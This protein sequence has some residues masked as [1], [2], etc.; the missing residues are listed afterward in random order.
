VTVLAQGQLFRNR[1]IGNDDHAGLLLALTRLD[2]HINAVRFVRAGS[3][4][5]T[6]MLREHAWRAVLGLAVL[7]VVWLWRCLPR[8]GPVCALPTRGQR[9]FAAHL[10]EAGTFLWRYRLTSVLLHGPRRAVLAAANRTGLRES[11]LEFHAL[12]AARSG[13][14]PDRVQQAMEG[15]V[16]HRDVHGFTRQMADLQK[17]H[18]SLQL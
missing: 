8:F 11:E 13:L 9:R 18:Q 16:S 1:F 17:I 12:L 3:V 4:S 7:L 14:S 10:E 15:A 6:E 5:L 2:P